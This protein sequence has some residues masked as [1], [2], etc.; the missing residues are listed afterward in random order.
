MLIKKYSVMKELMDTIAENQHL[1]SIHP[2]YIN[3]LWIPNKVS[4]IW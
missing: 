2:T 4:T 3:L 1:E